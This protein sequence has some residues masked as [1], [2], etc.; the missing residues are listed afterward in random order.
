MNVLSLFDGM[1]CGQIALERAGIAVDKYYASEID[2]YAV[3]VT[4][5]NY[6]ETI[7][8]GDITAW[9]EW[10]IEQPDIIMG[11]SP[12]Q[13]FSFAGKQLNFEDERSKLFFV[14]VDILKHYKPK[15]FL[16]ENVMMKQ[17]YQD[18]ISDM[19]GVHPIRIN[20]ALV[21]AQNRKRLYWTNIE[22]VEQPVDKGIVLKDILEINADA[23][24]KTHGKL[25]V[26]NDKAQ[27]LDANYWKGIDNHGQ[28][29]C[30]QV[31]VADLKG[32]D[33]IKRV[34]SPKGK[35]PTLSA[36]TG[37]N[38]EPKVAIIPEATKKGYIEAQS[39]D[40]V[41]MDFPKSKTGRGRLMKEKCNTL[42][43]QGNQTKGVVDQK[44][45]WRKLTPIECERLQTVDDRF[46]E[47][48]ID[49]RYQTF[50][51]TRSNQN[52]EWEP[53]KKYAKSKGV[54]N[55]SQAGKLNCAISTILG[56]LDAE[57]LKLL[58]SLSIKVSRV[59]QRDVE[60]NN[61]QLSV[62]VSSITR[63]GKEINQLMN[64]KNVRFVVILSESG[65]AECVLSTI[66]NCSEIM[67]PYTLKQESF[68]LMETKG[69]N[70]LSMKTVDSFIRLSQKKY[71][72]ESS[73]RVRLS[74]ISI[75]INL[76][77]VKATF[78]CVTQTQFTSVCMDSSWLSQG[79]CLEMDLLD[80]RMENI[81]GISNS[82]RYKLLGNGWTVDVIA[83]I[84]SYMDI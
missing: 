44:L 63:N 43:A 56:S 64:Q 15:Y 17:E 29:T 67:I 84:F 13:G 60:G 8:L 27:C 55:Q 47:K 50:I 46:T 37:G 52:K 70:I 33:S 39:G 40:G 54:I 22:G 78:M 16:L 76:I 61:K 42:K 73:E 2:K 32:N 23:V 7:Q 75:L 74:I 59:S 12:C 19:L 83:H 25:T 28:R 6:P 53:C 65:V 81:I 30:I 20:S 38:Q 82:A 79:K 77:I 5:K 66:P 48:G 31:G 9:N 71:L 72:E 58:E 24:I 57:L 45:S 69:E 51:L 14:F 18:K 80:L 26:K 4:Q 3:A 21:S 68:N 34:Y 1:S 49:T 10:D 36:N 35:A 62:S 41:D 11:G